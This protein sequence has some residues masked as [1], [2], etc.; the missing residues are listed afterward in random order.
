MLNGDNVSLLATPVPLLLR[1][2]GLPLQGSWMAG[3]AGPG[4]ASTSSTGLGAGG[5]ALERP[6]IGV[7][8]LQEYIVAPNKGEQVLMDDIFVGQAA[9]G[10]SLSWGE[11]LREDGGDGRRLENR[12][13]RRACGDR[14]GGVKGKDVGSEA[15][16]AKARRTH[17]AWPGEAIQT[18]SPRQTQAKHLLCAR[19]KHSLCSFPSHRPRL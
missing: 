14:A 19:P 9:A 1:G 17:Q 10:T 8:L 18:S 6:L 7:R 3:A 16:L 13:T 11:H 5:P 4:W 2:S 15:E 12:E